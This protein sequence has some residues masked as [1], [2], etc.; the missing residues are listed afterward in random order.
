MQNPTVLLLE[1]T[2]ASVDEVK[3]F[4]AGAPDESDGVEG[5]NILER[6]AGFIPSQ[7]AHLLS[8]LESEHVFWPHALITAYVGRIHTE[9]PEL[10]R[11]QLKNP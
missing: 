2:Q 7:P 9:V 1:D 10:L 5:R 6:H 3:G 11:I 4:S 8:K